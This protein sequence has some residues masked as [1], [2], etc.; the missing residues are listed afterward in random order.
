MSVSEEY[1]W[2]L[3]D[4]FNGWAPVATRRMFGGAAIY[5][6]G[7]MFALVDDDTLYMRTDEETAPLFEEYGGTPFEYH[8]AGRTVTLPFHRVPDEAMETPAALARWAS[9]AW[10][11]ALRAS[12]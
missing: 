4:L 11:S 6:D 5:R 3:V 10:T 7:V 8:R 2:Q 12:Y 1:L 9:L